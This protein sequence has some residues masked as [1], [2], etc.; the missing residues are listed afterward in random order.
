MGHHGFQIDTILAHFDPEVV[1]LLWSKFRLKST[2]CRK[3]IFK[4]AAVAVVLDF[5][6]AH[7]F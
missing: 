3:L 4:I 6:S 2:R 5:Q 1:L 7:Q